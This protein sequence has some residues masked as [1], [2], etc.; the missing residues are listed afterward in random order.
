MTVESSL[1][2]ET[3]NESENSKSLVS[4]SFTTWSMG[5][6]GRRV[7]WV[8][9]MGVV[10]RCTSMGGGAPPMWIMKGLPLVPWRV[11]LSSRSRG[12][13]QGLSLGR[14]HDSLKERVFEYEVG[15]GEICNNIS[16]NFN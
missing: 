4:T 3:G 16:P 14:P 6:T 10:G 2:R 8:E 9:L 11:L 5:V 13:F 1:E 7:C 15:T 12:C